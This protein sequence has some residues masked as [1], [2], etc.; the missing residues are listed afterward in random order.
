MPTT[1]SDVALGSIGA[2]VAVVDCDPSGR[3]LYASANERHHA[4]VGLP[5]VDLVGASPP[6]ILPGYL[7]APFAERV[8]ECVRTRAPVEF[9]LA[10]ERRAS[11]TWWRTTVAP[12]LRGSDPVAQVVVTSVDV[13]ETRT[14]EAAARE[15]RRRF[16]ALLEALPDALITVDEQHRIQVMNTAALRMFGWEAG[17]ILQRSLDLLLPAWAWSRHREF[18]EA[19]RRSPVRVRGMHERTTIRGM[20]RSGEEFPVQISISKVHLEGGTEM[21]ALVR[22]VSPSK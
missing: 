17:D 16:E 1:L 14:L 11:T 2:A 13:T 20:R 4:M 21:T 18:T 10:I 15:A 5:E 22:E 7:A 9:D 12:V 3:L 19:F 6:D 8:A